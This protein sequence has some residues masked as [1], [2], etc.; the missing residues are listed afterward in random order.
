MPK[1]VVAKPIKPVYTAI[2]EYGV[3]I[4]GLNNPR[5]D[6]LKHLGIKSCRPIYID[7][8]E[9]EGEVTFITGYY[10]GGC[11]WQI[12]QITPWL[13]EVSRREQ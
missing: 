12:Y 2:N 11:N 13:K 6:L 1:P 7:I 5:S 3:K 9:A 8:K 4:G 10:A